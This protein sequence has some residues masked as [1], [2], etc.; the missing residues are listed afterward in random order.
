MLKEVCE[1][2]LKVFMFTSSSLK[3]YHNWRGGGGSLP[4][5]DFR[6]FGVTKQP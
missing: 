5:L 6:M 2:P 1:V 4:E 3:C